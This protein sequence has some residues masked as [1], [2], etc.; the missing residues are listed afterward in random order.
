M[1]DQ[2]PRSRN[3]QDAETLEEADETSRINALPVP[4]QHLVL[5]H[6]LDQFDAVPSYLQQQASDFIQFCDT[7][8]IQAKSD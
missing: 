1:S 2:F 3:M 4:L 7:L 8:G 6:H 5:A